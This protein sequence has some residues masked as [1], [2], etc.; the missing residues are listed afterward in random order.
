MILELTEN[1]RQLLS[2]IR[3]AI[4]V[5]QRPTAALF[6]DHYALNYDW[7][8]NEPQEPVWTA[9]DFAL[10]AAYQLI[11]DFQDQDGEMPWVSQDE[12][13]RW[14]PKTIYSQKRA[15]IEQA[16]ENKKPDSK[17]YGAMITAE[18]DWQHSDSQ[19]KKKPSEWFAEQQAKQTKSLNYPNPDPD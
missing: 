2:L 1:S 9:W 17:D 12:S 7:F 5:S 6:R 8:T 16:Q 11:D 3:A 19:R 4:S 14:K 18:I 13:L 10:L 15:V